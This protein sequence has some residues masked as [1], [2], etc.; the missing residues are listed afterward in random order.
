MQKPSLLLGSRLVLIVCFFLFITSCGSGG[1]SESSAPPSEPLTTWHIRNSQIRENLSAVICG[2]GLFVAVGENGTILTSPDGLTWTERSSG[3]NSNLNGLTYGNGLFVAVGEN[4]TILI[5]PDGVAWTENKIVDPSGPVSLVQIVYGNSVFVAVGG[6]PLSSFLYTSSDGINW[7][8]AS[9]AQA[10]LT[11]YEMTYAN[12]MFLALT[13]S[14]SV[15]SGH[16]PSRSVVTSVDGVTWIPMD[17]SVTSDLPD[18]ITKITYGNGLFVAVGRDGMIFTSPDMAKWTKRA[19]GIVEWL[20]DVTYG[21]GIFVAA[22]Y[23]GRILD[24]PDGKHWTVRDTQVIG[25]NLLGVSYGNGTF[26]AVGTGGI[27]LQSD[28]L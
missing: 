14:Y 12:G 26:V 16:P 3:T 6:P 7:K 5:S 22:G 24:S 9:S 23:N 21:A 1:H 2:N 8:I 19:S 17:E 20:S 27:I 4:G 18:P 28:N 11:Y 10:F 13:V 15:H 25:Q